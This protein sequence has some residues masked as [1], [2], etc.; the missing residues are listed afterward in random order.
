MLGTNPAMDQHPIRGGWGEGGKGETTGRIFLVATCYRT[1]NPAG[2][3]PALWGAD[4]LQSY[5]GL[6]SNINRRDS[7]QKSI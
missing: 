5:L 6:G 3:G 2:Q 7:Y 4:R 1:R